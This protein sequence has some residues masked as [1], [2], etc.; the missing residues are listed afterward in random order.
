MEETNETVIELTKLNLQ[1]VKLEQELQFF[2]L[3]K[4]DRKLKQQQLDYTKRLI[5]SQKNYL[6]IGNK[7]VSQIKQ[8]IEAKKSLQKI[9][10]DQIKTIKQSGAVWKDQRKAIEEW[11]KKTGIRDIETTFGTLFKSLKSGKFA[12]TSFA[13]ANAVA[14]S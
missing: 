5:E 8:E 4:E 3:S 6:L 11:Q 10:E 12:E 9:Y 1:K 14:C 2:K 7:H 13:F